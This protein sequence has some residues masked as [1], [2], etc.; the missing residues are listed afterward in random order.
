M[1]FIVG[2][3]R[4]GTS[5][6]EQILA[7]HPA[8]VPGGELPCLSGTLR[9]PGEPS[10]GSQWAVRLAE[11]GP[12]AWDALGAQYLTEACRRA[13]VDREALGSSCFLTDKLPTN[14]L[15]LGA[16]PR[17]LPGARI[18]HC[19]RAALDA[20]L[21]CFFQNFGPGHAWTTELS[22]I[23]SIYRAY[24]SQMEWWTTRAG[25]EVV[26]LPYES[27][28]ANLE[29]EVRRLLAALDLPFH[30]DCLTFHRSARDVRTASVDQVRRPIY[31]SSR[32]R[33]ERYRPWL[34]PLIAGLG[35][36]EALPPAPEL[37]PQASAAPE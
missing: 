17:I 21:S 11:A 14:Y 35:D 13:G 12:E 34:G 33:A 10:V 24:R 6:T 20:C 26:P 29:A 25:I 31:Q 28:V 36:L 18:I 16:I 32:G 37:W 15:M 3:L 23:A 8:V 5:L 27:L 7:R 22:W 1:I 9:L 19:Q 4:S 30:P 2:M